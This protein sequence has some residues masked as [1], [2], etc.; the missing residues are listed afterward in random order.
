[1]ARRKTGRETPRRSGS[2]TR[3]SP[4]KKPIESYDHKGRKR[5]NN[6]PVGLVTP[7]SD[8]NAGQRK[9]YQYDP[10]LV[11]AGKAEHPSPTRHKF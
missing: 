5:A 9:T 10:H 4:M 3:G 1:M 2:G 11:W 8:P 6:P 7:E